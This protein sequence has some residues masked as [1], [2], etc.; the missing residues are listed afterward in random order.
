MQAAANGLAAV[1]KGTCGEVG[2]KPS[3]CEI[4]A[5]GKR[6]RRKEGQR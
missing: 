5:D 6:A 1:I 2:I 3:E 4:S